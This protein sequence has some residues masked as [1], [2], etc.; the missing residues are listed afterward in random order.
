M[1]KRAIEIS[2]SHLAELLNEYVHPTP[3]LYAAREYASLEHLVQALQ[4]MGAD[5]TEASL[6]YAEQVR[7]AKTVQ[8]A[9]QLG[10][11]QVVA[12]AEGS[13]ERAANELVTKALAAGVRPVN[14]SGA[15]P[16][17]M[18]LKFNQK[19]ECRQALLATLGKR[20]KVFGN[21]ALGPI[22]MQLRTSLA[23]GYLVKPDEIV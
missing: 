8:L 5:A 10:Q 19:P 14:I 23:N 2:H 6:A 13:A 15:L 17:L 12:N 4:F 1:S 11:M 22:L 21:A 3:L 7:Q 16:H 18:M 9:R 20:L